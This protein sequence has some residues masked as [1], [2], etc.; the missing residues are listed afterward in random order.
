MAKYILESSGGALEA[1]NRGTWTR[2]TFENKNCCEMPLWSHFQLFG[3]LISCGHLRMG[4]WIALYYC[5]ILDVN[6]AFDGVCMDLY[7]SLYICGLR[8]LWC[9]KFQ[10]IIILEVICAI[11]NGQN[12]P[13]L[14]FSDG[15]SDKCLFMALGRVITQ[16]A[17]GDKFGRVRDFLSCH[18]PDIPVDMN[19]NSKSITLRCTTYI[20]CICSN[21]TLST[22]RIG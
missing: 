9:I 17:N 21:V 12:I 20:E 22:I 5:T 6:K 14:D 7:I 8:G 3:W 2:K 16:T 15:H 18:F 13:N 11:V 19:Y 10:D 4:N 1:R